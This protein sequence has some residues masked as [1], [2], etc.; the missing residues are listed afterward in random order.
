MDI[1]AA[2]HWIQDNIGDVGGDAFNITLAGHG[3]GA[4]FVNLLMI[5]PLAKGKS[6]SRTQ[7]SVND[8]YQQSSSVKEVADYIAS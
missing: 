1:V 5:S 4:D 6:S 3:R 7:C 2:L 8:T